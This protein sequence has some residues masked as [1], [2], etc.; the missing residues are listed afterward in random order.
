[1]EVR[2]QGVDSPELVWGMNKDVGTP[3]PGAERIIFASAAFQHTCRGG[4]NGYHPVRPSD[5]CRCILRERE[6]LRVH[7]VLGHIFHL[8]GP[9]CSHTDV[10]RDKCVWHLR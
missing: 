3:L 1:M 9:K 7:P 8:D 10:Q 6:P 5:R 2:E 4:S